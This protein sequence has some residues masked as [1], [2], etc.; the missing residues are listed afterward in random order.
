[1]IDIITGFERE[2]PTPESEGASDPDWANSW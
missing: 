1:M 2:L